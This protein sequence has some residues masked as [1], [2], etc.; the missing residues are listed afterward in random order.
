MNITSINFVQNKKTSFGLD[1]SPDLYK[2]MDKLLEQVFEVDAYMRKRNR[3]Y[4]RKN[5]QIVG[6]K[7][8]LRTSLNVIDIAMPHSKEMI[9]PYINEKGKAY[10]AVNTPKKRVLLREINKE[11]FNKPNDFDSLRIRLDDLEAVAF[12]LYN[13]AKRE[14]FF[15]GFKRLFAF[16]GV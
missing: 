2:P 4:H 5:N 9:Y 11:K 10:I 16:F 3:R 14:E 8:R 12:K 13:M 1:I 15:K 6:A 7:Q